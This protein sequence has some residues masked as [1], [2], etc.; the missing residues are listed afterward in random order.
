MRSSSKTQEI[1]IPDQDPDDSRVSFEKLQPIDQMMIVYDMLT[2]VRSTIAKM[3]KNNIEFQQDQRTYRIKR[4]RAEQTTSLT[5]SRKIERI[6]A[7]R[8]DAWAYFR[9]RILPSVLIAITLGIL[10]LVFGK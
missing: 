7:G 10:Y 1:N 3:E 5:T 9:D 2:Y 6:L 4:E 8:F